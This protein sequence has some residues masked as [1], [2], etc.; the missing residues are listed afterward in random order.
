LDDGGAQTARDLARHAIVTSHALQSIAQCTDEQFHAAV[1]GATPAVL[2]RREQRG[3]P[4][5]CRHFDVARWEVPVANTMAT[6]R[7]IFEEQFII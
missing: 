7:S 6:A 2:C 5:P 3:P 4:V 1:L